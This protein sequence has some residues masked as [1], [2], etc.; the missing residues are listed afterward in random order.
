MES[1]GASPAVTLRLSSRPRR[2]GFHQNVIKLVRVD[3]RFAHFL[4][5]RQIDNLPARIGEFLKGVESLAQPLG[6]SA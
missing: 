4:L 5:G 1:P 6:I 2:E 3:H